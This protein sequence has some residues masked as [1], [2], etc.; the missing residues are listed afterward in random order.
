MLQFEQASWQLSPIVLIGSGLFFVLAGLFI[1]LGG[2]GLARALMAVLGAAV[3]AVVGFFLLGGTVV[4]AVLLGTASAFI[5]MIFKRVFISI[6]AAAVIAVIV[7]S[8]FGLPDF[9]AFKNKS[10][11][12]PVVK[13]YDRQFGVRI[14]LGRIRI[15]SGELEKQAK[16]FVSRIP[17][18]GWIVTALAV[19]VIVAVGL[20]FSN[21]VSAFCCAAFG[22][23]FIFAGLTLLLLYKGSFPISHINSRPGL[24]LAIFGAMVV[25]GTA[26]QL[27]LCR[28]T[29]K[30]NADK[31]KRES[32]ESQKSRKLRWLGE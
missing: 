24:Y 6:L 9:S 14:S 20:Y 26:E 13:T 18:A 2:L 10:F 19:A 32:D 1:W 12:P 5:G 4:S 30:K 29:N 11:N 22:A 17:V 15:Y 21:F 16:T 27:L 8:Y 31:N 3:G 7:I 28:K 25:F 23:V